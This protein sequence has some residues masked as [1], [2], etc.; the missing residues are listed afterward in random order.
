VSGFCEYGDELSGSGATELVCLL[1]LSSDKDGAH[2]YECRMCS[3]LQIPITW[4]VYLFIVYLTTI[5]HLLR[6][7]SVELRL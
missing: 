6:L 2:N 3:F 1:A 5:N 4:A 7:Y